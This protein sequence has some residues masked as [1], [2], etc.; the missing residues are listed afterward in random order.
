MSFTMSGRDGYT[1]NRFEA[2]ESKLKAQREEEEAAAIVA[3]E[4][5]LSE[6]KY[7]DTKKHEVIGALNKK[8]GDFKKRYGKNAS[9]V[10]YAVADK[11]AKKKGDTSKSD[12]RYA[13]ESVE[14]EG[15]E[16]TER[17]DDMP[18]GD[19]GHEVHKKAMKANQSAIDAANKRIAKQGIQYPTG[20]KQ[21]FTKDK[22]DP[23]VAAGRK[24]AKEMGIL[25]KED[26]ELFTADEIEAL[27]L[28]EAKDDCGCDD[29]KDKKGAKPD[30]LDADKD[31]NEKESMKDALEDKKDKKKD[32]K[33]GK[34]PFFAD[35][36][37]DKEEKE[38]EGGDLGESVEGTGSVMDAYL[39]IYGEGYKPFPKD[40]V[41]KKIQKK[42][43]EGKGV[44]AHAMTT[45][46]NMSTKADGWSEDNSDEA[47]SARRTAE[48]KAKSADQRMKVTAG[49]DPK[50]FVKA[51][52]DR[53]NNEKRAKG[54]KTAENVG[55]RFN[56]D[57]D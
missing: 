4:E 25:R 17:L 5:A 15:E 21:K 29:K 20:K 18:A 46:K 50:E 9:D 37:D 1:F 35:K 52:K 32:K 57:S 40:K 24:A 12:D 7:E 53:G 26:L 31:G 33:G 45:A 44:D 55:R 38:D 19:V 11:T 49:K 36:K 43:D 47:G 39:S 28:D 56:K 41:E 10:M 8:K 23:G 27:G 16:L 6:G 13:Y 51:I 3:E 2:Y 34:P 42:K 14:A 48:A 22:S 30:F 54:L